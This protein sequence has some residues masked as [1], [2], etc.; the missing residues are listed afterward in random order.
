MLEPQA[1]L[2]LDALEQEAANVVALFAVDRHRAWLCGVL[3]LPMTA[4][5]SGEI[6]AVSLEVAQ[7]LANFYYSHATFLFVSDRKGS[8][9]TT[10]KQ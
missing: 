7:D 8:N 10:N 2:S 4:P 6:P 9:F 5:I 1:R 3:K